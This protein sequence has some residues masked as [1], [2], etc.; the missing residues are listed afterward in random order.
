MCVSSRPPTVADGLVILCKSNNNIEKKGRVF[1][2]L[3]VGSVGTLMGRRGGSYGGRG[4]SLS[5]LLYHN[6]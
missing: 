4:S 2:F 5:C 1:F 3:Y 6:R